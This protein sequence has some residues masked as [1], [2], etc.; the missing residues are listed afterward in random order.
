MPFEWTMSDPSLGEGA[1]RI[2]REQADRILAAA[3]ATDKATGPRIH[4]ARRRSKRLRGLIRLVRADFSPYSR[5]NAELRDAARLLSG[6][7]D[8]RVLRQA[9]L[10][11]L[12]RY[13]MAPP[14][15]AAIAEDE[16]ANEQALAAFAQRFERIR[17]GIETWPVGRIDRR[18]LTDGMKATYRRGR[19]AGEAALKSLDIDALHAWRKQVKYHWHHLSLMQGFDGSETRQAIRAASELGDLLGTHHDL[20]VLNQRLAAAPASLGFSVPPVD[21]RSVLSKR[22]GEIEVA[23]RTLHREVYQQRPRLLLEHY[24]AMIAQAAEAGSRWA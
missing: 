13:D 8:E 9:L 7:R 3:R 11:L 18:T 17:E 12:A 22:Q 24:R 21:V 10:D 4:D 15:L 1:R 20:A 14:P 16:A 23:I 2:A 19:H 6:A 5:T